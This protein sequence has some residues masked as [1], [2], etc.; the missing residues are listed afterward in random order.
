MSV[1]TVEQAKIYLVVT[2]NHDDARILQLLQEAED[3]CLQYLDRA[4]LPRTG[5][6]CPDECD[7]SADPVSDGND[8]AP[9]L[10]RGILLI[11]QGGYEGKDADEMAK[12]RTA[13]EVCWA[14]FRCNWG[15]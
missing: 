2:H 13:A 14:P 1:V 3:E 15:A 8:L 4:A 7:T 12:L 5:A 10:R 9:G 6:A 11:V